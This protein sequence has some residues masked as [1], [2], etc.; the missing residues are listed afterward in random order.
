[1]QKHYPKS[2]TPLGRE[3]SMGPQLGFRVLALDIHAILGCT[4]IKV[5]CFSKYFLNTKFPIFTRRSVMSQQISLKEAERKAFR[6][7]YNDGLWDILLGCFVLMFTIAPFLSPSLG[8]FWSAVVFLPF[9]GLVFLAIWL[10]RKH[11]VTPR[12]GVVKLGRARKTKLMKFSVVMLVVNVVALILGLVAALNFGRVSGQVTTIIFGLILLIC[13]SI[14]AYFLD[15]NRLYIY[16]LLV[17]L[18]PLVGEWLY[19][20]GNAA[21]HGF[22]ITFGATASIMILVALTI[23][24]RLLRDNPVPIKGM[25][26]EEA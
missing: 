19:I 11:V 23:F 6:A 10:I 17:G 8:D 5:L 3:R 21:H 25:P 22:P 15:F 20:Y 26:T 9:W 2:Q 4:N 13:F 18:S 14:A 12:I 24:I 16:G 7:T 1:V